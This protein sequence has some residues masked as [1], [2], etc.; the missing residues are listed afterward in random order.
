MKYISKGLAKWITGNEFGK[1]GTTLRQIHE[2]T[3]ETISD[4]QRA[5]AAVSKNANK[6]IQRQATIQSE[7][8]DTE[9]FL[10]S[11]ADILSPNKKTTKE[12]ME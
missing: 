7:V 11:L 6:A 4:C 12:E 9:G 10:E 1:M 2:H 8:L 3:E 5:I